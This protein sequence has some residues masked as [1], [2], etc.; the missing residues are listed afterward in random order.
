MMRK[1]VLFELKEI[2]LLIAREIMHHTKTSENLPL[3]P[4]QARIINYLLEHK[5]EKVYQRDLEKF[6]GLRRSTISG[7]LQTMERNN[8]IKK[9]AVQEDARVRQVIFTEKAISKEKEI[10]ESLKKLENQLEKDISRKDLEIF[11]KVIRQIKKNLSEG[12]E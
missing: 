3:S 12:N 8:M 6:L 1:S 11:L 5:N 2:D 9:I 10:Q 7:V 4:V